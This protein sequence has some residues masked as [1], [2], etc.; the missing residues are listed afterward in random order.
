MTLLHDVRRIFQ[1]S[2]QSL[3][4]NA[5]LQLS[6]LFQLS[7]VRVV[8]H[9]HLENSVPQHV[10]RDTFLHR[11]VHIC[12]TLRYIN[13]LYLSHPFRLRWKLWDARGSAQQLLPLE[14]LVP[15][16]DHFGRPLFRVPALKLW[17]L[18]P[19]V[20][21]HPF[22][23]GKFYGSQLLLSWRPNPMLIQLDVRHCRGTCLLDS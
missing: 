8:G 17:R 22:C 9:A 6:Q 14:C 19:R 4:M 7:E 5:L 1:K 15:R 20:Q 12:C 11:Q 3:G 16:P 10:E 23:L 13:E 2:M 21:D 18:H